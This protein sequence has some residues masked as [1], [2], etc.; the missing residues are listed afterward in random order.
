MLPATYLFWLV[1]PLDPVVS[2]MNCAKASE[3]KKK[4]TNMLRSRTQKLDLSQ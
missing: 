1:V 3:K 2:A 4:Q